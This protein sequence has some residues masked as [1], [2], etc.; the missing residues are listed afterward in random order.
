MFGSSRVIRLELRSLNAIHQKQC[1]AILSRRFPR[2]LL[3]TIGHRSRSTFQLL[4]LARVPLQIPV[5]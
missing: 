2:Q 1:E 4:L 3:L 5:R